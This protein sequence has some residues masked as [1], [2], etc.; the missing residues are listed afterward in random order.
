MK[1]RPHRASL[2]RSMAD[3]LEFPDRAAL[4]A[5]LTQDLGR[6]GYVLSDA[7][8][9]V[10]PYVFDERV[11]WNTHIVTIRNKQ[12][13]PGIWFFGSH[14]SPDYFGAIGFTDGPT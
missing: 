12:V 14:V 13:R 2:R 9:R 5:H 11:G 7:D 6:W 1:F 10:D 8:V 3:V 4:I